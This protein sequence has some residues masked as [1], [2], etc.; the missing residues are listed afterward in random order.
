MKLFDAC[1]VCYRLLWKPTALC[2]ECLVN[3]RDPDILYRDV[4]GLPVF[5]LLHYVYPL[6]EMAKIW[7]SPH[8]ETLSQLLALELS[9]KFASE[10]LSPILGVI[11]MPAKIKGHH[12]HAYRVAEIVSHY[13]KV[14]LANQFLERI[15]KGA[16]QKTKNLSQ[17]SSPNVR[18]SED[19][20]AW[21]VDNIGGVWILVDDIVTSG[22][23]LCNAWHIL[24]RPRA[25]GLTLAATPL[26]MGHSPER[27][28]F[29]KST[30]RR[31]GQRRSH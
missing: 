25:V 21:N 9:F 8:E 22:A 14:P 5:S 4:K 11:P 24:G 15:E 12:D 7:K 13:F 27:E 19:F 29:T 1:I 17:R 28:D 6:E 16:E 18:L 10:C 23:T 3:F 31:S 2:H 20:N 30:V 26:W